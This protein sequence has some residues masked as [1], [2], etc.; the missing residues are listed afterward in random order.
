MSS[1]PSTAG[2]AQED[3]DGNVVLQHC[4]L[5][6]RQCRPARRAARR[7]ARIVAGV[8]SRAR[9]L[10]YLVRLV[11][12][13]P[14]RIAP[15]APQAG[16]STN[17]T[18]AALSKIADWLATAAAVTAAA[19]GSSESSAPAAPALRPAASAG[20]CCVVGA[21]GASVR[22]RMPARRRDRSRSSALRACWP[23]RYA[24]VRLVAKNNAASVAV[25]RDR[26]EAEPRAPNTVPDA[27]APKPAPASAP[28]PRCSSTRPTI[29]AAIST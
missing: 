21:G 19:A 2:H 15:P 14:T 13:E 17:S 12:L 27:P 4:Q 9:A 11:G 20:A 29:A 7:R 5:W 8:G 23:P 28:L 24:S 16:V 10:R 18:T 3:Q 22:R 26:N 25:M 1:E 6:K